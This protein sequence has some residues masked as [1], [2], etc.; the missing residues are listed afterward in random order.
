MLLSTSAIEAFWS[1]A[2]WLPAPIK[3]GVAAICWTAVL[4]YLAFAGRHAD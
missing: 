1:S 3:Y 4:V 2:T